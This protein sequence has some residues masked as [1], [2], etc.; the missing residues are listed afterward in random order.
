MLDNPSTSSTAPTPTVYVRDAVSAHRSRI[1]VGLHKKHAQPAGQRWFLEP[2]GEKR[3]RAMEMP[4]TLKQINAALRR[5]HA[6]G[7]SVELV[8]MRAQ[9]LI[10]DTHGLFLRMTHVMADGYEFPIDT[11]ECADIL[12]EVVAH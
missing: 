11:K 9:I 6:E 4:E 8:D 3:T 7:G 5:R 2:R 1:L 10:D 12:R